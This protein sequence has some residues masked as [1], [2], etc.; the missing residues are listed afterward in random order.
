[1]THCSSHRTKSFTRPQSPSLIQ[2]LCASFPRLS[3]MHPIQQALQRPIYRSI[4]ALMNMDSS[5]TTASVLSSSSTPL[6][7]SR[8]T[9]LG[10]LGK[11]SFDTVSKARN[12]ITSQ[13][14]ALK[15]YRIS[16]GRVPLHQIHQE[17]SLM[18]FCN[19]SANTLPLLSVLRTRSEIFLVTPYMILTLHE[20]IHAK[21]SRNKLS[22]IP[23]KAQLIRDLLR[24]TAHLHDQSIVH[25]DL[26]PENILLESSGV[27]KIADFGHAIML[28]NPGHDKIDDQKGTLWYRA[29]EVLLG[30]Q[31]FNSSVDI[32]SIG[33]IIAVLSVRMSC[34]RE[35]MNATRWRGS[36]K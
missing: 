24:G 9:I 33:C 15:S 26:K 2:M 12:L 17:I 8:Y 5:S 19:H 29:P 23:S 6:T 32:W 16:N 20:F 30:W 4:L 22:R 31:Y 36:L 13:V 7:V 28:V 14:V 1:M 11:G 35:T 10:H 27:L 21:Q 34:L 18:L 3:R 25:R